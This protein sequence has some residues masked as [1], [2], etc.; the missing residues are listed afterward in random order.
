MLEGVAL[1]GG[2]RVLFLT[3]PDP[4]LAREFAAVLSSGLAAGIGER[5]GLYDIRRALAGVENAMFTPGSPDEIPWQ[6][7]FFSWIL[8][9]TGGWRLDG[10][11]AREIHRVLAPGG[12]V[13]LANLDAAPLRE[14]GLIEIAAKPG[15]VVL[16]KPE[17]PRIEARGNGHFRV[18]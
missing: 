4:A 16:R 14:L 10:A 17:E 15:Y 5:E 9:T 1:S 13:W 7:C 18:L 2:D 8:D 12:R 3:I 11:A 6:E